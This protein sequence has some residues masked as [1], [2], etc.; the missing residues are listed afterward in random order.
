MASR[1]PGRTRLL[2][3]SEQTFRP[4]ATIADFAELRAGQAEAP[5]MSYIR[6][7]VFHTA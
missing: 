3:L 5:R 6:G 7:D 4:D 2:E 1:C